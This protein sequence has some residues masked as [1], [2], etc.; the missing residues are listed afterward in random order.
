MNRF[1][2]GLLLRTGT[3]SSSISA[4]TAPR[5]YAVHQ[6]SLFFVCDTGS[7]GKIVVAFSKLE[8]PKSRPSDLQCWMLLCYLRSNWAKKVSNIKES[9]VFSN[10]KQTYLIRFVPIKKRLV[11]SISH[12]QTF[13]G[14]KFLI[15]GLSVVLSGVTLKG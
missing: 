15:V 12:G 2:C 9:A 6:P 5:D 3:M 7:N 1:R 13:N 11:W 8:Q 4:V 10:R 14:V